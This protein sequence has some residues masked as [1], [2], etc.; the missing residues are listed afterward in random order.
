MSEGREDAKDQCNGETGRIEPENSRGIHRRDAGRDTRSRCTNRVFKKN[1]RPLV[2][3]NAP[4]HQT[5]AT[6][7]DRKSGQNFA[8][9]SLGRTRRASSAL[10]IIKS[11]RAH[12]VI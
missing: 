7:S 12:Q 8:A 10:A 6:T 11:I 9:G 2:A 3:K 4:S 5:K 1:R